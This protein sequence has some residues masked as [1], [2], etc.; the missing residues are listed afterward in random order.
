M[1]IVRNVG[2]VQLY[3]FEP[4]LFSPMALPMEQLSMIR[5]GRLL[6]E[7]LCGGYKVYYLKINDDFVGYCVVSPGGR[8]LRC[9]KKNDIVIGPYYILPEWRGKGYAKILVKMTLKFCTYDFNEVYCWIHHMNIPSIRTVEACGMK[10]N[11]L[12]LNVVGKF[13]KLV[14]DKNGN[15]IVYKY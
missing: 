10:P 13:R 15:Y 7:Y 9:S 6:L 4:S 2:G 14:L 3:E 8:R 11:G 5:R 1:K 12:H